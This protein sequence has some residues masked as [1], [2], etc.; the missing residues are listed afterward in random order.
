MKKKTSAILKSA[1]AVT[2][3]IGALGF[4]VFHEIIHRDASLPEKMSKIITKQPEPVET[5]S[6]DERSAWFHNQALED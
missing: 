6:V 3:V 2:G 4:M 5:P 1:G